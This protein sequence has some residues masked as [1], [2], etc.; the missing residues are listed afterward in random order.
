[1]SEPDSTA[2]LVAALCAEQRQRWQQGDRVPTAAYLERHPHL[3]TAD[4]CAVELV[5]NEVLLREERGETPAAEEYL[6]QFPQWA[7][8]LQRLFEVHEALA[9]SAAR[10]ASTGQF[11]QA[12][13]SAGPAW[14][15]IPGYEILGELG[16]GGMGVVYQARHLRLG[17]LVALKVVLAGAHAGPQELARFRTEAEA[18]A[19]L[20][21]PNIVQIYD[22][23]EHAGRPYLALECVA[24][25]SLARRLAGGSLPAREAA[26]LVQALAGAMHHA[27]QQGI[28][29]RDLKPANILLVAGEE[30]GGVSAP[31]HGALTRPRSEHGALTPPPSL[32]GALTPPRS[33]PAT[34]FPKITDFGL[35]KQLDSDGGQT[36][37]GAIVGTPSYMAPEQ[38]EGQMK[39]AGP[40]TDVYALGA[41]LYQ[42][43]TG[44]PPFLAATPLETLLQVKYLAPVP[45]RR[46]QPKVGR[47]LETICLKCLEK[48]P[49]KRY[50]TA[51]ALADDL[52]CF[53]GGRPIQ[54]RPVRFPERLWRACRRQPR[55]ALLAA[56]LL[57]AVVGGFATVTYLWRLAEATARREE[58]QHQ[59]A[60]QHLEEAHAAVQREEAQRQRA[61]RNLKKAHAAVEQ[62]LFVLS[63]IQLSREPGTQALQKKLVEDAL[64][65][66]QD[67]LGQRPDAPDLQ[68]SVAFA[69]F[70]MGSI[71]SK[72][73]SREK[74]RVEFAQARAIFE[75]L[76][77]ANPEDFRLRRA[78]ARTYRFL[79]GVQKD[80]GQRGEA[81]GSYE[82]ARDLGRELVR[83][84]SA[85]AESADELGLTY[86]QLGILQ[87]EGGD[88]DAALGAYEEAR[89]IFAKLDE[90]YPT[91]SRYASNLA[92]VH[93]V[94]GILQ[95]E[96]GQVTAARESFGR[97]RDIRRRLADANPTDLALQSS[98]ATISMN[99]GALLTQF[100]EFANARASL[101]EAQEILDKLARVNPTDQMHQKKLAQ[102][103]RDLGQGYYQSGDAKAALTAYKQARALFEKLHGDNPTVTEYQSGLAATL[104]V[105]SGLLS[106]G[107]SSAEGRQAAER[108]CDLFRKLVRADPRSIQFK[109]G[110][111]SSLNNQG[112]QYLPEQPA[113][114]G[115]LHQQARKLF[116]E[117]AKD[118][119]QALE[120]RSDL[121]QTVQFQGDVERLLGTW[122][123]ARAFYQ[124]A[125]RQQRAVLDRTP[126]LADARRLL[127]SHYALLA[128]ASRKTRR[129]QEAAAAA[130][131]FARLR[132][133][134]AAEIYNAACDLAQCVPL[135][136]EGKAELTAAEQAERR[137]HAELALDLLHQAVAHGFNDAAHLQ[138]DPDLAPL[139]S[140]NAFKALVADLERQARGSPR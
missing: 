79:G 27:H 126:Q 73:G 65:S 100:G 10:A 20:Q 76:V 104:R 124:E 97:V 113:R 82:R 69:H 12:P 106:E 110:L 23:G 123:P 37:S 63:Q 21:H 128:R 11:G 55:V 7:P 139:R 115:E 42:C 86:L 78:L 46:L 56:A 34:L 99:L 22:V 16:R 71:T 75:D 129:P 31:C 14:P 83:T 39:A 4:A 61:D 103:H 127:A 33:S 89:R 44:R 49:G 5:Y 119:P 91:F 67:F 6:R 68:A 107:G 58:A 85:D 111:A 72:I 101:R 136:A 48:E 3:A 35:A 19:R 8:Q 137:R 90:A 25:G 77:R 64:A 32:H 102:V 117:L 122:E 120:Y 59:R 134:N 47:D 80:T 116:E 131:E 13:P 125:V 24:G 74:A 105:L 93:E 43:L 51:Q 130:R 95:A 2:E 9:A 36:Q 109:S 88:S 60:E 66:F 50:A 112:R 41:V 28:V 98:L 132:P 18:A 30:R 108:A 62:Y 87:K 140:D 96:T 15:E 121:A 84:G 29:H 26:A 133:T 70:H 138:K 17:R 57:L 54:A 52:G 38:A 114:A 92:L 53:L 45:P 94:T 81:R 118:N 40:T 135:V 1:M